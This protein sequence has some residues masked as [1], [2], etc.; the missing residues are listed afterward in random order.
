MK[1]RKLIA[2]L[3]VVALS[4]ALMAGC[5]PSLDVP[6]QPV[7]TQ[8]PLMWYQGRAFESKLFTFNILDRVGGGDA[9]ITD[10]A[11]SIRSLMNMNY[12]IK[13]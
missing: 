11:E 10:D 3:L 5:G 12:D 1:K 8:T 9:N 13:R 2:I 4:F 7:A 6:S